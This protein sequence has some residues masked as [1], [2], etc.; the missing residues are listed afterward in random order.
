[1]NPIKVTRDNK[2]DI[3]ETAKFYLTVKTE[4]HVPAILDRIDNF[5]ETQAGTYAR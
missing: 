3:I 4:Q 5:F 2:L 1:M